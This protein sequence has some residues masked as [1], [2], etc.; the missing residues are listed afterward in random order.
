[1][2]KIFNNKEKE[3]ILS[4]FFLFVFLSFNFIFFTL[5]KIVFI[6]NIIYNSN[7]NPNYFRLFNIRC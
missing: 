4:S 5:Y 1:M 2:T 7:A 6:K 3:E